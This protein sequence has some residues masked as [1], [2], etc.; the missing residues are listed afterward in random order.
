MNDII[1]SLSVFC[2]QPHGMASWW[3][4]NLI[5]TVQLWK[6]KSG[7]EWFE[8]IYGSVAYITTHVS[9]P[10]RN[11]KPHTAY[12][13][14]SVRLSPPHSYNSNILQMQV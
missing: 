7:L 12:G 3:N 2:L 8:P 13:A 4:M 6:N 5:H 9:S 11:L 1:Y 14:Q 10:V